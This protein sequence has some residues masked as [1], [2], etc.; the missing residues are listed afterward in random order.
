MTKDSHQFR[1]DLTDDDGAGWI[2]RFLAE[3][4]EFD[5]RSMWR[6]ASWG[7]GSVGALI[8][9]ILA[10]RSP[11]AINR[12]QLA[13]TE[14]ARQSQQVQWIAKESQNKARELAAAVE[15]L[16]GDRDRLYTRITILEQGLD[17]VTGALARPATA[18]LPAI[19]PTT[20]AAPAPAL[21]TPAASAEAD[22]IGPIKPAETKAEPAPAPP[23]IAPVATAAPA[24]SPAPAKPP[25][26]KAEAPPADPAP[27]VTAAIAPSEPI[28][29]ETPSASIVRKTEFG[30]DLGGAKSIEGLRAVWRGAL[31]VY[32]QQLASLQPIIVVKERHDGLGMQ[33]R[34]VAGPLSDAAEAAKL[35]AGFLTE[36][37]RPCETS[38]YEGQRLSMI[39]EKQPEAKKPEAPVH[40]AKR[41]SKQRSEPVQEQPKT[42][43]FSSFFGN[44]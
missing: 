4:D 21:V 41:R 36:S 37:N 12:D 33:L 27:T 13:S 30:V 42:S 19:Q 32:S 17:S 15:T 26:Q 10:T 7:V 29:S 25:E 24:A 43:S 22:L 2:N 11:A 31:K 38:V 9:A 28:A 44:R 5:G 18:T 40:R 6:L 16:N 1:D 14:I 23:K 8:I 34:L 35:C 39:S 3:E 20:P